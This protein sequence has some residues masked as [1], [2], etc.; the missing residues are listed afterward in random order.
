MA[1]TRRRRVKKR[2]CTIPRAPDGS[3]FFNCGTCGVS[4]AISLADM[5]FCQSNK[6]EFKRESFMKDQDMEIYNIEIDR[7]GFEKW[8]NMSEEEKQPFV[9][10]ARELDNKHQEALKEEADDIIKVRYGADSPMIDEMQWIFGE[11]VEFSKE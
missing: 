9:S 10:R 3:A 11:S 2:V 4:V 8:K 5:H 7:I 1:A 6:M